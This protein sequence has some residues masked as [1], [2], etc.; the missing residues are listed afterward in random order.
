MSYWK[1]N[2]QPTQHGNETS[3]WI[4]WLQHDDV[5]V[6]IHIGHQCGGEASARRIVESFAQVDPT[7]AVD[8]TS[9]ASAVKA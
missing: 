5:S 4:A 9:W 2:R 7:V 1:I 8:L 3:D 6:L